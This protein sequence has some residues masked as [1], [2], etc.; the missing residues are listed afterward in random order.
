MYNI[1]SEFDRITGLV[2][3]TRTYVLFH[4]S[5]LPIYVWTAYMHTD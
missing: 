4:T 1:D 5:I 2:A 3:F